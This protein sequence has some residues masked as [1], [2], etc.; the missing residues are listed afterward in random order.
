MTFWTLDRVADAL[1]GSANHP[2]GADTL[3]GITT[4]SRSVA[5]GQMFV[6]LVGDRFDGHDFVRTAVGHGAKAVVASR[7]LPDPGVPVFQVPDTLVALGSLG[8]YRRRAW[9]GKVV[10][11]AGS[12]GKTTTKDLIRA[13]L[14]KAV[15]VHATT[16]NLNNRIGVP[17]TLLAVGDDSQVA[18]IE[19][20]TN[21]PGEV[22]ILRSMMSPEISVVTS[23]G[24]EHLEGL[25]DIEGVLK[26]ESAAF[27]GVPIAVTPASQPEIGEAARL[28]ATSVITAGLDEGD[29]R[30]S[31]WRIRTDGVGTLEF[32]TLALTPPLRGL[33]NLRN[34]MLAMAVARSLGIA[35]EIAARGIEEMPVPKMRSAWQQ[36]GRATLVNDAYNANPGST[37]AA[38]DLMKNVGSGRQRVV[39]LGTMRELGE[40]AERCH[41]DIS[42]IALESGADVVA[43]VGDFAASLARVGGHDERIVAADTVEDLWPRLAPRLEP[44]AVILLKASRGVQLEQLVP[45]LTTWANS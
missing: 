23:I 18:V 42:R 28:R 31:A 15:K 36:L 45:H 21:L 4:D 24:E 16:G 11:V 34:T 35:D 32:G 27:D 20:G 17:L 43:G 25:G 33:H 3:S 26:E 5:S 29:L 40:A 12:N 9:G 6:A 8:A 30:P 38:L 7:S 41:D 10:M 14:S 19:A 13:A 37:R 22:E 2:R 39:V 44:D 1:G